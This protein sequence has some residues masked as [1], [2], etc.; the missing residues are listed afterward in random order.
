MI[1]KQTQFRKSSST[2]FNTQF[3]KIEQSICDS[4]FKEK[5]N[6]VSIAVAKIKLDQFFFLMDAKKCRSDIGPLLKHHT[7][8]L[9]NERLEICSLLL[10]QFNSVFTPPVANMIAQDPVSF[11]SNQSINPHECLTDIVSLGKF[12]IVHTTLAYIRVW[13]PTH[14]FVLQA[15][16]DMLS[17]NYEN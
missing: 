9:V 15:L 3:I 7:Q 2:K 4:Q 6:D 13:A 14:N 16:I 17:G 8:L 11:F 10:V 1:R 5:L 12:R